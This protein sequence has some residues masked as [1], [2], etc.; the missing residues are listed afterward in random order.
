M[1]NLGGGSFGD[2]TAEAG[3]HETNS[4]R[5]NSSA[6][7][8]DL[9][10]DGRLDLTLLDYALFN[11]DMKQ[12]CEIAPGVVTSCRPQTYTP[13][14]GRTFRRDAADRFEAL[15]DEV[16]MPYASGYALVLAYT[17]LDRDGLMDT[18]IG[19]DGSPAELLHNLGDLTF[20]N[21][22]Q[23]SGVGV[24]RDAA[25]AAMG[26]DF[27]DYDRDGLEDLIV[28]DFSTAP[29]A[30]FRYLGDLTFEAVSD[31]LGIGLPTTGPLGFG[32]EWLEMDNDGWPDIA[33]I[34]G[35]VYENVSDSTPGMAYRQAM[36]LFH[37]QQGQFFVDLVPRLGGDVGRPIVGRGSATG[38]FDNDGRTDL[39][40]VDYEG[41]TML[42]RNESQTENHWIRFDL[43]STSGNRYAYGARI[44]ARAGDILWTIHV[45]PASSF[46]SSADPRVHFGLGDVN[47]LDTVTIHWPSGQVETLHDVEAD[48]GLV[49]LE[50]RGIAR[51][52]PAPAQP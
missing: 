6:G 43:R 7:F 23:P 50:G 25:M 40:V 32:A 29:Y 51:R 31:R 39:L 46:L 49:I 12:Y 24:H 45:T 35:H 18:Y 16:G 10:R 8:M 5:W 42:L 36:N 47:Q 19:N 38:D 11:T 20:V 17:D 52:V 27:A 21:I 30:V 2:A 37:N 22:G 3:L 34:N 15:P 4:D 48:Q 14:F 1:R 28:T 41:P 44:E 9:D 26:S 13:I 33:F